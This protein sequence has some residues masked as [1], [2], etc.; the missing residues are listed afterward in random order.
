[1]NRR[2]RGWALYGLAWVPVLVG[3]TNLLM[4]MRGL[5]LGVS[6]ESSLVYVLSAALLGVLVWHASGRVTWP[7]QKFAMFIVLQTVLACGFSLGWL[8]AIVAHMAARMGVNAALQVSAT[9]DGF[10]LLTGLWVY[11]VI[12]GVSYALRITGRLR[13]REAAAARAEA[14]R[15]HAELEALRG[16]LNPHFLFNTL[17]TVSALLEKDPVTARLALERFAD[18]LRYVLDAKRLEQE[19]VTLGDELGFVRDYLA[20]EQLRLGDRLQIVEQ[21]DLETLDCV[22]PS[23]TLQPLVE[24]AIKHAI[25]PRASGGTITIGAAL[26]DDELILVIAD[27]GPGAVEEGVRAAQ[28]LG[29]RVGRQRLETRYPRSSR[30][31]VTTAPGAG[32]TVTLTLPAR[33]MIISNSYPALPVG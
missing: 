7:D 9:F 10:Q 16:Q 24:N 31:T 20:L 33:F 8:A 12:A 1:V 5:P 4:R 21:I 17:H 28:G 23:L 27:D 11:G 25:S 13:E 2:W 6:L 26:E 30:F 14:L 3:Y 29:L 32:F 22:I 18:L 19:E 15:M